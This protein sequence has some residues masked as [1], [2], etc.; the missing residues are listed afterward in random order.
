MERLQKKGVG[1]IFVTHFLEQVYRVCNRITVLRNGTLVGEY[2]VEDLPRVPLVACKAII[3]F[4][5]TDKSAIIPSA[6]LSSG[7]Y[8]IPAQ[9]LRRHIRKKKVERKKF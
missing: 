8:A 1:I 3:I 7:R 6:F 5:L 4:S 9:I 2:T